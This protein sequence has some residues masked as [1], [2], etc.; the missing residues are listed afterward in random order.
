MFGCVTERPSLIS[1]S[2]HTMVYGGDGIRQYAETLKTK[3]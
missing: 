1:R 2:G 3:G